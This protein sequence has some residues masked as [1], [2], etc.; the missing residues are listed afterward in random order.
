MATA[1]RL[2]LQIG[3][4]GGIG[5]GKSIV[6][7]VFACL[8]IAIYDADSRAKWLT[9]H[10]PEIKSQVIALLGDE[11]Y[12]TTG[13][14]NRSYVASRV[15]DNEPL[16]KALN[17]IIHPVV[18]QDTEKWIAE[19]SN[20]PYVIKEAALMKAAG[21]SNTLDYVIVVQ[22]PEPIRIQRI[23]QRDKRSEAEIEAIIARQVSDEARAAIAD[24]TIL[25]DGDTALIPQVLD[26]HRHFMALARLRQAQPDSVN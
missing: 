13:Q 16:L 12:D 14:Y 15:F 20:E 24:F 18:Y 4:T 1:S 22:A 2:P 19:K 3:I 17:K 21:D 8:G 9:N 6:C 11:A 25:N 5:S 23:L 7:K 10:H 26:L